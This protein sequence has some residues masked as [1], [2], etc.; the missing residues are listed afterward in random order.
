MYCLQF[1]NRYAQT[2][3]KIALSKLFGGIAP[4]ARSRTDRGTRIPFAGNLLIARS[5]PGNDLDP[6][7]VHSLE[8]LSLLLGILV[9]DGADEV[10]TPTIR[11]DLA[12]VR[13]EDDLVDQ[14]LVSARRSTVDRSPHASDGSGSS[15][16]AASGHARERALD[17]VTRNDDMIPGHHPNRL[18]ASTVTVR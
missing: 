14:H 3:E 2:S 1:W 4:A 6:S 18:C 10:V 7:V 5:D 12:R 11:A 8:S 13:L 9:W 17:Q 16:M 15:G